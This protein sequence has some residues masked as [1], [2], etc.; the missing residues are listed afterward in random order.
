MKITQIDVKVI[1][2]DKPIQFTTSIPPLPYGTVWLRMSTDEGVTGFASTMWLGSQGSLAQAI[3]QV[4]RPIVLGENPMHRER[5]WQKIW[6]VD[7]LS[8]LSML[9]QGPIDVAIW[10][11]VGKVAGLP[12]SALM[13][14]Y[15]SKVQ[16][17]AS[18]TLMPSVEE[19]VDLAEELVAKGFKAIKL[20]VFGIPDQDMR[21][22]EKVRRAVGDTTV[23]MLDPSGVYSRRH[24]LQVGEAIEELAYYW[25]EEPI[26]DS[27]I[28]GYLF[29]KRHLRIP[30]AGGEMATS[31]HNY[32]EYIRRRAVDMIRPDA[33][34]NRGLTPLLKT[35]GMCEAFGINCEVHSFGSSLAQAAG[36]HAVCAISNCDYF[37]YPIPEGQYDC[38]MVDVLRPDAEGYV[39]LPTKPG[40]GMDVDWKQI[41]ELA[42]LSL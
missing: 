35:A 17:Y 1:L 16:A 10:D 9:A 6:R 39:H 4:Y 11:I 27:D 28:D 18:T 22:C 24:A 29:L 19:Y 31:F 41:E 3:A 37:E 21:V 42:V 20:H 12:V 2:A 30:L 40:L 26:R 7:R 14:G 15:R 13:G 8:Q 33:L 25:Y 34:L 32:A 36:L 38:G 23:L 5:I